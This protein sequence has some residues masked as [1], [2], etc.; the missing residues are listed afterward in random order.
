MGKLL[1]FH[2][3]G[4][5]YTVLDVTQIFNLVICSFTDIDE[6]GVYVYGN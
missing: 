2:S 5:Y 1:R 3:A 6:W 4:S